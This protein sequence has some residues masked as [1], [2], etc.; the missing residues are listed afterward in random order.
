MLSASRRCN[1]SKRARPHEARRSQTPAPSSGHHSRDR[2]DHRCRLPSHPRNDSRRQAPTGSDHVGRQ[3]LQA[4]V[5][6]SLNTQTSPIDRV[7]G[8]TDNGRVADGDQG[9]ALRQC[10]RPPPGWAGRVGVAKLNRPKRYRPNRVGGVVPLQAWG[11]RQGRFGVPTVSITRAHPR[12]HPRW[13]LT[14]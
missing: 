8:S 5:S 12:A 3:H 13:R 14:P 2:P 10:G 7:G 11:A 9:G 6:S 1:R 4:G